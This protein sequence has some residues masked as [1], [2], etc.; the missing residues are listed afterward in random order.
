MD[1]IRKNL[2][3][4]SADERRAF[5]N[6][7]L[8]INNKHY[9]DGVSEWY[10]QD[11]IHQATHVHGGASFLPWHRE[12]LNRFEKLLQQVDSSVALHYWDWTT[13][14]RASSDGAGG[15]VNLFTVDFMGSA[16][17]PAGA[18][19][20]G[21][22]DNNGA[23]AGSRN[24]TGNEADP[25]QQITRNLRQGAPPVNTDAHI[26][27]S[28][29]SV[30]NAEQWSTFR[31][32]LESRP[33]HNSIHGWIGGTIGP[34]HTA[35]EDPFVFVMHANIDR[36]WAKWQTAPGYEWRLDPLQVYG[37][38][39]TDPKITENL[40]PWAGGTGTRPWA[41]PDNQ[42][43]VKTSL[44]PSV[45]T[46]PAYDTNYPN[47][48]LGKYECHLY[49]K[50]GKNDWHYV[51]VTKVDDNTL[52]W[53]NRA[54]VS[55]SLKL[56]SDHSKLDVSQKCPYYN[57]DDGTSKTKYTQ[58]TLVWEGDKVTGILGPWDELYNKSSIL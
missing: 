34:G 48:I 23:L 55:W 1:P 10:K 43:L 47:S 27:D 31:R 17:G 42:Q 44:D 37:N 40:Q 46:P 11:Q 9:P 8:A 29:N 22:L 15:Q 18:P 5:I 28:A 49:D 35:F 2:A 45:V 20:A 38:E 57:F 51:T 52:L 30:T 56:T 12:L 33:N 7:I 50:K 19:I 36:L 21:V 39:A 4:I 14:P 25:P 58:G 54:G 26:V 16:S 6:A 32:I 24:A 13:D 41:A 3:H 53:S